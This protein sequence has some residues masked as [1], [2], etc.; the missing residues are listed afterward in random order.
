MAASAATKGSGSTRNTARSTA[1]RNPARTAPP[2]DIECY[3]DNQL[4][5]QSLPS[6]GRQPSESSRPR[7]SHGQ[8]TQLEFPRPAHAGRS[9]TLD[10]PLFALVGHVDPR[11]LQPEA[12][13]NL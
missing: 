13:A 11:D 5:G 8:L 6:R 10:D 3:G 7:N 9:E 1:E 12:F 2:S 4:L